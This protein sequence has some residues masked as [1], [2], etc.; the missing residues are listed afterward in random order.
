MAWR[1]GNICKDINS[2]AQCGSLETILIIVRI[3]VAILM[4]SRE[5]PFLKI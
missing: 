3:N 4:S 5:Y 1:S 2:Q